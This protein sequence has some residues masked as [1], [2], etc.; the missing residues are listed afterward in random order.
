MN[1][2]VDKFATLLTDWEESHGPYATWP[3]DECKV[4]GSA[5]AA[6]LVTVKPLNSDDGELAPPNTWHASGR[7]L[8]SFANCVT[9]R[10][11]GLGWAGEFGIGPSAFSRVSQSKSG[12]RPSSLLTWGRLQ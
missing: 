11:S 12:L 2:L 3:A 7:R 9:G 1:P 5:V 6:L 4:F 8:P 10:R